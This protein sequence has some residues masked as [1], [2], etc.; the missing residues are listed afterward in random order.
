MFNNDN[1]YFQY[2]KMIENAED[3]A[4]KEDKKEKQIFEKEQK[5]LEVEKC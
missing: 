5:Q 3:F 1:E 4:K 2:L